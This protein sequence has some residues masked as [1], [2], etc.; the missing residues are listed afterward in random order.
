MLKSESYNVCALLGASHSRSQIQAK[1]VLMPGAN[2]GG[3]NDWVARHFREKKEKKIERDIEYYGKN[4][5][6]HSKLFYVAAFLVF[7][8]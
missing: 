6:K 3:G 7:L 2:L 5:C 8:V 4:K 1:L